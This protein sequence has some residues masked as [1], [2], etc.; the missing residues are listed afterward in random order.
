MV[1]NSAASSHALRNPT[2]PAQESR[3]RKGNESGASKATKALEAAINKNKKIEYDL[4]IDEIFVERNQKIAELAARFNKDVNEVRATVCCVSR[5]KAHRKPT[6]CN[7]VAHQRSLD[8]QNQGITK[9]MKD[10]YA[11]LD[12]ELENSAFS[13]RS[14]DKV[15]EKRLVDQVLESRAHARRG[16]CATMKAAQI[17]ARL[18]AKQIGDELLDLF[19]RTGVRVFA[20]FARGH[21]DDPS[22]SHY[23]DSDDALDFF[24][25][26]LDMSAPHFMRKFEQWLM[27]RVKNSSTAVRK[28]VSRLITDRLRSATK[29]PKAKMD[30]VNYDKLRG[31]YSVELTGNVP[32]SRPATWNVDTLRLVRDG[33]MDGTIDFMLM[34]PAQVKEL[35]AE[36]K[37]RVAA[38]GTL[39]ARAE[40]SDKHKKRGPRKGKATAKSTGAGGKKSKA[41]GSKEDSSSEEEEDDDDSSDEELAVQP[42]PCRGQIRTTMVPGASM[43]PSPGRVL[44][45]REP[46]EDPPRRPSNPATCFSTTQIDDMVLPPI[47]STTPAA[48][49]AALAPISSTT[50]ALASTT[51]LAPISN[52]TPTPASTAALAPISNATPAP[53]S[54]AA[55]V[56]ISSATPAPAST[57]LLPDP[58]PVFRIA[59]AFVHDYGAL[60]RNVGGEPFQ[61][62]DETHMPPLPSTFSRYSGMNDYMG[63][64]MGMPMGMGLYGGRTDEYGGGMDEGMGGGALTHR[65]RCGLCSTCPLRVHPL[66]RSGDATKMVS[67]LSLQKRGSE[68]RMRR[69]GGAGRA[70]VRRAAAEDGV[71]GV[72]TVLKFGPAS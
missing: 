27:K 52:A 36:Q 65:R 43:P 2:R 26:G 3:P 6:L 34:T 48:S 20:F 14:I 18:T 15:E 23:V 7:G 11:E 67:A 16:P 25:Q 37:A 42:T 4:A 72:P 60:Q 47:S 45:G 32:R 55:L 40:R 35:A 49:T 30:Y 1:N 17:D 38:G 50:P 54:T 29:N 70:H 56:P 59:D 28:D 10:L 44:L 53:A 58:A 68:K 69:E 63:W 64:D 12:Q 71:R 22:R 19:E 61:P 39:W 41:V 8:L 57:A 9:S 46:M 21:A 33:L 51:A 62:E 66:R 24:T 31:K 13:Y 5:S